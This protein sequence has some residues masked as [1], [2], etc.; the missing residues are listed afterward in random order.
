MNEVGGGGM[1]DCKDNALQAERLKNNACLW[2]HLC[3]VVGEMSVQTP[4]TSLAEMM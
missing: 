1:S 3:E 4:A 2:V